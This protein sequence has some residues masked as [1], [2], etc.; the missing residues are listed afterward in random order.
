MRAVWTHRQLS[1]HADEITRPSR[2]AIVA[3]GNWKTWRVDRF[4]GH[5]NVHEWFTNWKKGNRQHTSR[6][7]KHQ[8]SGDEIEEGFCPSR[9]RCALVEH[10]AD[11]LPDVEQN[12][13]HHGL[14]AST[15]HV[16]AGH[17]SGEADDSA[18]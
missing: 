12:G 18:A 11:R 1:G 5:I 2:V 7:S 8:P 16:G 13:V 9:H 17:V 3:C 10:R 14:Q 4:N 6:A 15:G